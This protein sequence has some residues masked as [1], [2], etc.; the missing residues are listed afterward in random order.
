MHRY[1]PIAA[2]FVGGV[3]SAV[4]SRMNGQLAIH[5][6]SGIEAATFSFGSGLVVL[7]FMALLHRPI[8]VGLG[9]VAQA[10]REGTLRRW[11]VLGGLLGAFFVAVQSG[12]VPI[13]GV[14]IFIVAVVAG[15]SGASLIVDRVGL[16]PAGVQAVT[17]ARAVSAALAILAVATAVS[18]R[19]VGGTLSAIPLAFAVVAG[20]AVAIQS[21]ING[22]VAKVA[23]HPMSATLLNF[24]LGS[25]GLFVALLLTWAVT[26][27]DLG[28]LTGAPVLA[29]GGGLVGIVFIGI[30]VWSVPII[31]VL[32]FALASIAGQ[33][34]GAIVLDAALPTPGASLSWNL[35]AGTML[36]FMAVLIAS[37]RRSST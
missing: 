9:R 29:Y 4:Q 21:A 3:L 36:A 13:L 37:R 30:A 8:R 20:I 33:L 11:Q 25:L 7:L 26:D 15:Q 6:G 34:A 5:T 2:A 22:R 1:L 31:G 24:L 27:Q 18:D 10:V 35:A 16:G 14:A 32:L 23:R 28:S 17:I 12:A 19:I